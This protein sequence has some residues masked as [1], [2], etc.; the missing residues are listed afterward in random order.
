MTEGNGDAP[1][2]G[3]TP[4]EKLVFAA[5][6]FP[7]RSLGRR[8][9][10]VLLVLASA[11]CLFYGS[12]FVF[13]G[14]WPIGLFLGADFLLLYGAFRLNYRAGRVREEVTVSRT[15]VSIRKILPSGQA[16]EHRFNPVWLRFF[17]HREPGIGI[18]SMHVLGRGGRRMSAHISIRRIARALPGHFAL[19]FRR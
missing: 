3:G 6:L 16:M 4:E 17:V 15:D 9:F 7:H 11:V 19:R 14:A 10:K 8:G 1:G 2:D 5:E 18:R 13:N 12:L